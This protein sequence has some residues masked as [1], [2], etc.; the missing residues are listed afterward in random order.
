MT[1]STY[2]PHHQ[3]HRERRNFPR[4][5]YRAKAEIESASKRWP[6]EL[7]DLSFTGA[8]V[9]SSRACPLDQQ[10]DL[11][12]HIDLPNQGPIKMRGRLAHVKGKYWGIDCM[13]SG[14]DHRARL[15]RLLNDHARPQ[16]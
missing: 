10:D 11:T 1:S 9:V 16:L 12:L 4:V 3:G 15:H 13:P 7:V 8:L 2:T 14:V 6:V 5:H